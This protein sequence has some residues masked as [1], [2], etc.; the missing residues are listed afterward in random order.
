MTLDSLFFEQQLFSFQIPPKE[1]LAVAVSGGSDSLCLTFLLN[2][3]AK[4][5][6]HPLTALTVNHNIRSESAEEANYVHTLL[7][8]HHIF[9]T[10]LV[11]KKKLSNVNLEEQAR[12]IRYE[13]L[14]NYCKKHDIHYLFLAHQQSDQIETFLARLARGSGTDGLS[15]IK[16]QTKKNGIYI[17][18]PLLCVS[19]KELTNF[20][21]QKGIS[22][23]EDPM[24]QNLSFERV[25][26]RHF[27][28]VL[29]ENGLRPQALTLAINRL[30]RARE[31]LSFY[32]NTFI[33][34]YVFLS[35]LG[36]I[37]VENKPFYELPKE[38][39]I[40]VLNY[41]IK[42][43]GQSQKQLSLNSLEILINNL[44]K[45]T[46]LGTCT[47]ISNQRGIFIA[48]ESTRQEKEKNIPANVQTSWDRF[49]IKSPFP[50]SVKA[51]SP[52]KRLPDIPLGVQKSF[53]FIQYQKGL[54]KKM[55]IDYKEWDDYHISI[56]FQSNTED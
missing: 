53:P 33:K 45:R 21:L 52:L 2:E 43:V 23:V 55:N 11:N 18:R 22:W 7:A 15:A 40:R 46:T 20:L 44:P 9:H 32:T 39:K 54:E 6:S 28:A 42:E 47:I 8:K 16:P 41:A 19:K 5:H 26:W 17:L 4:T 37:K 38:I 10:T 25:K 31:A 13:L 48:K 29:N 34:H 36:Y 3:F 30:N 56:L 51:S 12:N 24:N 27:L 1:A 14:C 50:V 35:P 49:L